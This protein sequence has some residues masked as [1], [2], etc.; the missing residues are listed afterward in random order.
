M[1]FPP[2]PSKKHGPKSSPLLEAPV[3][4]GEVEG[5]LAQRDEDEEHPE[6]APARLEG[7]LPAEEPGVF[8]VIVW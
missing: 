4:E 6:V 3:L 1:P 5:Q 8:L 7:E 2:S